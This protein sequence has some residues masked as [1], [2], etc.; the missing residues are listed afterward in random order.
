MSDKYL[1]QKKYMSTSQ[2][3]DFLSLSKHTIDKYCKNGDLKC[4]H[5]YFKINKKRLFVTQAVEEWIIQKNEQ[6]A[7]LKLSV[8]EIIN[9][10][11]I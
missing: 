1:N 11:K 6:Q 3:G 10:V 9:S 5:H 2:L 7:T 8:D 4:G